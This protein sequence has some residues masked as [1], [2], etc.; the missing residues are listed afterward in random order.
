MSQGSQLILF[1][2]SEGNMDRALGLFTRTEGISARVW[3]IHEFSL[4][5]TPKYYPDAVCTW[6]TIVSKH[7]TYKTRMADKAKLL[8]Q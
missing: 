3:N 8:K 7:V 5:V 2:T 1:F 4:I 6:D